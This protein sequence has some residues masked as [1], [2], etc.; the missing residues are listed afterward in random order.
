M[1][2]RFRSRNIR[3]VDIPDELVAKPVMN[4]F[5]DDKI[6]EGFKSDSRNDHEAEK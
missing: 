1:M 3:D 6:W 2:K 4:G 5:V